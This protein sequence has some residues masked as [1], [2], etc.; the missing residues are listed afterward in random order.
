MPLISAE[1]QTRYFGHW[2]LECLLFFLTFEPFCPEVVFKGAPPFLPCFVCTTWVDFTIASY[3]SKFSDG[4]AVAVGNKTCPKSRLRTAPASQ[5]GW[6]S[7]SLPGKAGGLCTEVRSLME[8]GWVEATAS[9]S[10][11]SYR[12]IQGLWHPILLPEKPV[13]V[14]PRC[15]VCAAVL[16]ATSWA[17][18]KKKN[19]IRWDN[20]S[21][22]LC[23]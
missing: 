5:S 12:A 10:E 2:L 18:W 7:E 20:L 11:I 17:V 13:P 1:I 21:E 6:R 4:L 8:R 22:N 3:Q 16:S 23:W 19:D 9:S 15:I 14:Q